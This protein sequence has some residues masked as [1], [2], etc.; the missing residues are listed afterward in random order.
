MWAAP[1]LSALWRLHT[2]AAWSTLYRHA[3]GP[4]FSQPRLYRREATVTPTGRVLPE[5]R[6]LSASVSTHLQA[7]GQQY[8]RG[9]RMGSTDNM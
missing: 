1:L 5:T 9:R 3:S 2:S 8:D 4:P 7:G 6:S